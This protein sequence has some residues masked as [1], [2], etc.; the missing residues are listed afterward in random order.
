MAIREEQRERLAV[1]ESSQRGAELNASI[2]SA[3][4]TP[5]PDLS[6]VN[7][8]LSICHPARYCERCLYCPHWRMEGREDKW[9]KH[10]EANVVLPEGRP[11]LSQSADMASAM[12]RHHPGRAD[13]REFAE[14]PIAMR[15]KPHSISLSMRSRDSWRCH[16]GTPFGDH[17]EEVT[18]VSFALSVP[19]IT[20]GM[21]NQS[22]PG[23]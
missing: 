20:S 23:C 19:S 1:C 15:R 7:S 18:S 13:L 11:S 12:R 4:T 5:R 3:R 21:R 10:A 8:C 9:V 16:T 22:K 17:L 2:R 14:L 6:Q